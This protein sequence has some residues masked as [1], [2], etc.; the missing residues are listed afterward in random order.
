MRAWMLVGLCLVSPL[1]AADKASEIK[2]RAQDAE[3]RGQ[4]SEVV[5]EL[6]KLAPEAH[7]PTTALQLANAQF[8]EGDLTKAQ[9][10]ALLAAG[11]KA[12][13]CEALTLLADIY[14]LQ[15]QI[16]EMRK[17]AQAAV[18]SDAQCT[19]AWLRLGQALDFE[20]KDHAADQA[21][22]QYRRLTQGMK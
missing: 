15:E 3:A 10:M 22:G 17:A 1:W 21:Y 6:G 7:S 11:P 2:R 13:R 19:E 16:D 14:R 5:A 9:A 4:Y 18:D 8:R 20:G 12:T